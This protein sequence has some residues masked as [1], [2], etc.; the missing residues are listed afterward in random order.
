M[1]YTRWIEKKKYNLEGKTVLV[2]GANSG[3]G[4]DA[5]RYF[6]YLGARVIMACRNQD[7][8]KEAR[9]K[10]LKEI[11]SGKIDLCS[12]DLSSKDS[13]TKFSQAIISDNRHID[14][15]VNNAGLFNPIRDLTDDGYNM[16]LGT[17]ALGTFWIT[18]SLLPWIEPNGKII[19]V[20]SLVD[21]KGDLKGLNPRSRKNSKIKDYQNSKYLISGYANALSKRKLLTNRNMQS[22][23]AH[24]GI[25]STNLLNPSKTTFG[26]LFFNISKNFLKLFYHNSEKACLSIIMASCENCKPHKRVVPSGPLQM[27]G[28]PKFSSTPE[29]I[30]NH[31]DKIYQFLKDIK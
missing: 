11:P 9:A 14:I 31:T 26:K 15:L 3:I 20:S 10:I 12:L 21:K 5:C 19:F 25:T 30:L 1:K 7:K 22:I 23:V 16:T 13:I 6:V 18:E 8:A 2:T 29:K 27:S 17:N 4:F 28:F 24:P